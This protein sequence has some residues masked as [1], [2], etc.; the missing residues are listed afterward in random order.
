MIEKKVAGEWV[1]SVKIYYKTSYFSENFTLKKQR[2]LKNMQYKYSF[3]V[4]CVPD[5]KNT[6]I[7]IETS[8]KVRISTSTVN[9]KV[10]KK[11]GT[12]QSFSKKRL[13]TQLPKVPVF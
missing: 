12:E 4:K 8:L 9:V 7:W 11:E 1:K 10:L 3:Y 6:P 13:P 5:P 2:I